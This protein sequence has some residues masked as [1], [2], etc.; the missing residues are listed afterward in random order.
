MGVETHARTDQAMA[1]ISCDKNA[2]LQEAKVF[3]KVPINSKK[4]IAA[5]TK[6]LCLINK[7]RET[8]T[9]VESTDVFFGATRLFES[10]DERL[11]RLVYLLIKSIHANETEIFIVTSSLTKDVNSPNQIYRANAIRAMCLVVKSNVASQVERYIKSSLVDRDAYVCSSALLCCIRIFMQMPQIVRRWVGEAATCLTNTNEM[12]QFH[13]TLMM[14]LVR[15]SDKQSLR[16]L[17]TTLRQRAMGV[18]TECFVIRFVA[19]NFNIMETECVEIVNAGLK[20]T[21]DAVKLE[22]LKAVVALA[23][24]HYKRVGSMQGFVFDLRD[25]ISTLQTMLSTRDQTIV[26]AA[27]RQVYRMA[28]TLPLLISVLNAKIEE[29]LKRKNKDISSLALLTL[30][31]TGGAETIERLLTHAASLSGDFK[32][33][34]AKALKGLCVSFP[35]KHPVVLKFF[36]NNF[37]DATAKEFK[38]EMIDGTMHI[39]E[40]IPAAQTTGLKN[41]CDFIEDCEYPELNAKVLKFLGDHVPKTKT[42]EE[43]VRYIYNRL[44]LENATVRAAGIEALDNIVRKCPSLK[45]SVSVLLLP[46][47][48]DPEDELRERVNLTYELMLVDDAVTLN[49]TLLPPSLKVTGDFKDFE[50]KVKNSVAAKQLCDVVCA[51]SEKG[52]MDKLARQLLECISNKR[53]YDEIDELLVD[54]EA[55]DEHDNVA[56]TVQE[57]TQPNVQTDVPDSADIVGDEPI[58]EQETPALPRE[59]MNIVPQDVPM[60]TSA[61]VHLTDEEEDYSVEAIVHATQEY[62]VLEF[63]IGNTLA[64]QILENVVVTVDYSVCRNAYNWKLEAAFPIE[65]LTVSEK[66]SAFAVLSN[67]VKESGS[68]Q[69][70][71][72]LLLGLV[73]V[74]LTF[75]AKCGGEDARSYRE[76]Y[77]AN[78]L[79]L[80]IGMY[81]FD[82]TLGESHFD[83]KWEDAADMETSGTFGL[84][85]KDIPEAV[86]GM[87]R[88]FGNSMVTQCPGQVDRITT[89]N[90]AGKLLDKHEFLAKATIAQ[91]DPQTKSQPGLR[92]GCILKLQIRTSVEEL[93]DII[94]TSLE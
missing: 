10:N 57:H 6:I 93:A 69:P 50:A 24:A 17:V 8:L 61:I 44:L 35:D 30:L 19:A 39:V 43:Y 38:R 56:H 72:G 76:S 12:V 75:D 60:A 64:D 5:I 67:T 94:F 18:H 4:C 62:V 78:D 11:R 51:V 7:G 28:Q 53:G 87:R 29:M 22:A 3:S 21:K 46:S 71:L 54:V 48:K 41:L 2:V 90:V 34:V 74:D 23:L 37:R 77:S 82:W 68:T 80:A 32:L 45:S 63:V 91:G 70:H 88:F 65:R 42:P 13:G 25:V 81:C 9:E 26:F 66:N 36:A 59:I 55:E 79:H 16:K 47:L 14:F 73:R 20:H 58:V 15:L 86:Q 27:M 49:N 84:Q 1:G 89:L 83:E 52:S 92:K 85:F 33:A 31:Q 40:R